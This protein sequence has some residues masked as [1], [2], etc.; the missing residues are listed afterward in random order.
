MGVAVKQWLVG[1]LGVLALACPGAAAAGDA[2]RA[3][4]THLAALR[5]AIERHQA[6]TGELPG[7][8]RNLG[9]L[10]QLYQTRVPLVGGAPVDGWERPFVYAPA[11]DTE[12]GYRLYSRGAN[13]E[14]EAGG[15]DDLGVS[16]LQRQPQGVE[17]AIQ[18][19]PV[20][21][22]VVV[23]PIGWTFIR[24]ARRGLR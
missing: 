5:S 7:D 19:L 23:A 20:L 16:E 8:A 9:M 2:A 11:T 22:L 21:A 12:T 17:R 15:G 6:A 1:A 4:R 18:L 14:D 24:A 3:T 13:G 10:V